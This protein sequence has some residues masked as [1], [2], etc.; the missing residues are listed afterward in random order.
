MQWYHLMPNLPFL[1]VYVSRDM[2]DQVAELARLT[3]TTSSKWVRKILEDADWERQL[4]EAREAELARLLLV[5]QMADQQAGQ[6]DMFSGPS[7]G[8]GTGGRH[9]PQAER[10][11]PQGK[12]RVKAR[13]KRAG[14]R[15]GG[16][17]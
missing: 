14:K 3:G 1:K 5:Q 13:R 8:K 6:A 10:P 7:P 12:R 15:S 17:R 2:R 4:V 9:R 11:R 16:G